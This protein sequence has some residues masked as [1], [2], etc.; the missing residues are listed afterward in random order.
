MFSSRLTRRII[1]AMMCLAILGIAVPAHNAYAAYL[2]SWNIWA[3]CG[4]GAYV[5][6]N[7][8]GGAEVAFYGPYGNLITGMSTTLSGQRTIYT[9]V[10][11]SYDHVTL[12]TPNGS[13][14]IYRAGCW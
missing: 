5:T 3:S 11:A 2:S 9:Y 14:V 13:G 8:L 10:P 12:K 6:V 1:G 7:G 4:R